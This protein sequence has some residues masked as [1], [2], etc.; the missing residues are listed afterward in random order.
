M[1]NGRA[2]S[3][4]T[5]NRSRH[6][7]EIIEAVLTTK[8]NDAAL[9]VVDDGSTDDTAVVASGFR[10]ITY[11]KGQNLGVGANKNRALFLMQNAAFSCIIEDDLVPIAKGWFE[12][13]E[14]FC[15][16][17]GIH[18]ICRVQD[19]EVEETVPEFSEWMKT[20]NVTP[21][22]GPSPRGDLT[23]L[24]KKVITDV[25][26]FNARFLGVGGA[27]GEW[28]NRVAKAGLIPHPLRWIDILPTRDKFQQIGDTEGGRWHRPK[29][30]VKNEIKRNVAIAK[31]L[32]KMNYI[33]H[34]IIFP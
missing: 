8:P 27:H 13:Y 11:V 10:G 20:K 14:D 34:P 21:V 1:L 23:F 32:R 25:G 5:Y 12:E 17:T 9:F 24:T 6:L 22:Y 30:D 33:Y 4:V 3:I 26:G 18:H 31:Q 16:V 28:S 7:G 15:L 2:I 29:S 19:K